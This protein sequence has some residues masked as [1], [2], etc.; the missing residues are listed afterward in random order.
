MNAPLDLFKNIQSLSPDDVMEL[1]NAPASAGNRDAFLRFAGIMTKDEG[2][3]M[4]KLIDDAC[5]R[6]DE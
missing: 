4:L 2:A 5:E 3:T 1:R 6:I